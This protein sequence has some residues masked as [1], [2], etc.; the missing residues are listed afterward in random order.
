M[1]K[2]FI[3]VLALLM[4]MLAGG[5]V[6]FVL[7]SACSGDDDTR[8]PAKTG[9]EKVA[10]GP[11]EEPIIIWHWG[12]YYDDLEPL[13]LALSTGLVNHVTIG[14]IHRKDK[15]FRKD[16]KVLK[17]IKIVK[18]SGV[19]L[20]WLRW[21]WPAYDVK[22]SRAEDLFD[23]NFYIK[24][25]R[26]LRAEANEIGADFVALDTE[27]YAYSPIQA[28]D[29]GEIILK[30]EDLRRLKAI[31]KKVIDAAGK[32]DFI[33]PAGTTGNIMP[34]GIL[35][36]LGTNRVSEDT[37]YSNYEAIKKIKTPYEIF[38]AYL[39][40]TR[41]NKKH[42]HLPYFLVPEIFDNSYLWSDRKGLYLY[43]REGNAKAVAE[44]LV[45]YARNLPAVRAEKK[46]QLNIK[47]AE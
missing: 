22:E 36:E 16:L 28:Y 5:I 4:V 7:I 40:T 2:K 34:Y 33:F 26:Y 43:P 6:S 47:R 17:A 15:D 27:A 12:S 35:S 3:R 8:S 10:G 13:K 25:I 24:E 38:G 14:T 19:K 42:P 41:E 18:D 21:L 1:S 37:Y 23:P 32:V 39:N 20:I 9:Q 46:P 45:K 31:I 44:E 11:K 29:K 30:A